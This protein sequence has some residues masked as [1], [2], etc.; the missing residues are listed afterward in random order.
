MHNQSQGLTIYIYLT[1]YLELPG[2]QPYVAS[3]YWQVKIAE[4]EKR[5]TALAIPFGLFQFHVMLFSL[6]NAPATFQ[7][8]TNSVLAGLH[9]ST[10]LVYLDNIIISS[11]NVDE[12]LKHL[13]DVSKRLKGMGLKIT[14]EKYDLL[15]TEIHYLEHILPV[16]P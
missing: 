2:F 6:C 16:V 5:N 1:S 12:H 11:K 4:Q 8:V 3:V 14:L 15:Q 7:R 10:S 13:K 9:W